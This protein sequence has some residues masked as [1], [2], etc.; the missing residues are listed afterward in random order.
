[1]REKC[2]M[3]CGHIANAVENGKPICA[4]CIGIKEGARE[5]ESYLVS[6]TVGIE[7]RM[8]KCEWC[9][10]IITSEWELPFFEY[11]PNE[12]FDSFYCGCIGWD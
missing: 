10:T 1:M 11:K 7:G 6:G 12:E 9:G 8:A 4:I 5:V 2:L 3:K